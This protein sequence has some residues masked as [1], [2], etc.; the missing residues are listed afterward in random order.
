V[1]VYWEEE[2]KEREVT[3]ICRR[4]Y[5]PPLSILTEKDSFAIV[6]PR[7]MAHMGGET[8]EMTACGINATG[9]DWWHRL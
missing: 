4:C 7:G 6:S 8:S 2:G 1:K 9:D 5:S 3:G